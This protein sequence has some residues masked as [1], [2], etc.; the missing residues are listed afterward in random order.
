[1]AKSNLI[2]Q[3][4]TALSHQQALDSILQTKDAERILMSVAFVR[5]QG[6]AAVS[7][8]LKAAAVRPTAFVGI[9]NEITSKQGLQ[10]LLDHDVTV[11]V[12]DTGST[13]VIYHPKLYLSKAGAQARVVMGSANLTF[14]GLFNNIEASTDSLLDLKD[15]ADAKFLDDLLTIFCGL[16]DVHPQH[17]FRVTKAAEVDA[18]LQQGRLADEAKVSPPRISSV[19]V[20]PGDDLPPMKLFGKEPPPPPMPAPAGANA[21]RAGVPNSYAPAAKGKLHLVWKSKGLSERDLNIPQGFNTNPTGSMGF[22]KGMFAD[23]DH[24][25]FFREV[26]FDGLDWTPVPGAMRETAQGSFELVIKGVN[27]GSFDLTLVHNTDTK[28]ATYAQ[29][30]MMT[31]LRWGDAKP[32]VARKDLLGRTLYLY[33][34]DVDPKHF[35]IDID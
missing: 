11:Y 8:A 35:R 25:H 5:S 9:R 6:V 3:G 19:A 21:K 10:A 28:S 1:M 32:L 16:P 17:V 29:G 27:H 23:I 2:V 24:R 15:K 31:S 30:N 13:H 26:V 20:A 14:Q 4:L 33:R 34:D 18:L 22:K 7:A 12:V